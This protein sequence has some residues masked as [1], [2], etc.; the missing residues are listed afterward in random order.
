[1]PM[2]EFYCKRCDE[3]FEEIRRIDKRDDEAVCESCG[4]KAERAYSKTSPPVFKGQGFTE[5][6]YPKN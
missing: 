2:Y 1:M 4:N 6:F 3:S 5:K